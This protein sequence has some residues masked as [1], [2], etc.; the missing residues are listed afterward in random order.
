M[1]KISRRK[2][3]KNTM[4][5][6]AA[7]SLAVTARAPKVFAD[8]DKGSKYSVVLYRETE[9]WKKYYETLK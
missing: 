8:R 4:F 2:F 9:E 3:T 7:G 6:V 5:A 1:E